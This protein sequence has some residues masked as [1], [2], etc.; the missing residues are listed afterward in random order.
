MW[1]GTLSSSKSRPRERVERTTPHATET[2]PV[3]F[4]RPIARPRGG[5]ILG[6]GEEGGGGRRQCVLEVG[7]GTT[8]GGGVWAK[9]DLS[10]WS[11]THHY[12]GGW[13]DGFLG[14]E[15]WGKEASVTM[16]AMWA[17]GLLAGPAT[18]D[19]WGMDTAATATATARA[20]LNFRVRR[21]R[22]NYGVGTRRAAQQ[23]CG[24]VGRQGP[25]GDGP[26]PRVPGGV[27]AGGA[28]L[29]W[30]GRGAGDNHELA[31]SGAALS[32]LGV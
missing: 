30:K 27:L 18:L 13:V 23:I 1:E 11:L 22:I 29:G 31:A 4:T 3:D 25:A 16:A 12:D 6:N 19:R 15:R 24:R 17:R 14:Y 9:Q 32:L 7:Q 21:G 20:C 8:K 26:K 5:D 2:S 28:T 10:F